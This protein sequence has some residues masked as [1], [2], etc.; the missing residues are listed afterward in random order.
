MYSLIFNGRDIELPNFS[1]SIAEKIEAIELSNNSQKK[2]KEKCRLMYS[3][4]KE[5]I[6]DVV[7]EIIGDFEKCDPND[8][9]VLFVSIVECYNQPVSQQK[10]EQLSS[11]F[12]GD[13]SKVTELLNSLDNLDKLTKFQK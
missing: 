12:N 13:L 1:F 3:F 4:E 8:I 11:L 5:L 10:E 2:F 9:S 7:D 6:G